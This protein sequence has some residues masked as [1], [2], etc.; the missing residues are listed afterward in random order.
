MPPLPKTEGPKVP[1]CFGGLR[2]GGRPVTSG[3]GCGYDAVQGYGAL[4]REMSE[5][6][7]ISEESFRLAEAESSRQARRRKPGR[8]SVRLCRLCRL[9]W[10]VPAG[11]IRA[12]NALGKKFE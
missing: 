11:T 5:R 12:P 6:W 9:C 8:P 3:A 10:L 7:G 4:S 2:V 1:Q